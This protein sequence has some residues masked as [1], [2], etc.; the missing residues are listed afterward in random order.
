MSNIKTERRME[1]A[2]DWYTKFFCD[3]LKDKIS[4]HFNEC[5]ICKLDLE[6]LFEQFPMLKLLFK[7][8]ATS[9]SSVSKG[10]EKSNGWNT[11]N[12]KSD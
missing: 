1:S 6:L 2:E 3:K 4:D 5:D 9:T 7:K 8:F 10:K 11:K 12:K